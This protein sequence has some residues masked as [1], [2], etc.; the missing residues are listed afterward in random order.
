M[1]Q[2]S[3]ICKHSF[4][5]DA[6]TQMIGQNGGHIGCPE[7]GGFFLRASLTLIELLTKTILTMNELAPNSVLARK[8]KRVKDTWEDDEEEDAGKVGFGAWRCCLAQ[9]DGIC[10]GYG[11]HD[12]LSHI[13]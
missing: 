12:W 5:R 9:W 2:R 10:R 6:V 11:V 8:V 1:P 4:S 13:E 7:S 3:K